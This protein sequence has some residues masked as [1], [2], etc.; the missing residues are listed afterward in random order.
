MH[1]KSSRYLTLLLYNIHRLDPR[2][3]NCGRRCRVEYCSRVFPVE[4]VGGSAPRLLLRNSHCCTLP[5]ALFD[6][7]LPLHLVTKNTAT[8]SCSKYP[9]THQQPPHLFRITHPNKGH[10]NQHS[11]IPSKSTL[12][13]QILLNHT[14]FLSNLRSLTGRS[15][16][17]RSPTVH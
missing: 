6:Y 9:T 15:P 11:R 14:H 1:N 13:I 7:F 3:A 2:T 10:S 8:A 16:T 17:G 5:I 4:F 12:L